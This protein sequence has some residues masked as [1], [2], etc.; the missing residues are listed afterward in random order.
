MGY[1][2]HGSRGSR[3]SD[4]GRQD[5]AVA[6]RYPPEAW[7]KPIWKRQSTINIYLGTKYQCPRR[8]I[9]FC[10]R[11][12]ADKG[13]AQSRQQTV[14]AVQPPG[15]KLGEQSEASGNSTYLTAQLR[16][17]PGANSSPVL[18][19]TGLDW[20]IARVSRLLSFSTGGVSAPEQSEC[21][22]WLSCCCCLKLKK[23]PLTIG[24]SYPRPVYPLRANKVDQKFFYVYPK[25]GVRELV[26]FICNLQWGPFCRLKKDFQ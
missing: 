3:E 6:G 13:L 2:L 4:G 8:A 11:F 18:R 19:Q 7:G 1:E 9:Y 12:I 20:S 17:S 24:Q 26:R 22:A 25:R 15:R 21:S 14:P 23:V 16:C 10:R 5:I